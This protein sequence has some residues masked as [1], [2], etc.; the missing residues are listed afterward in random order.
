[1]IPSLLPTLSQGLAY[2][3][4][5]DMEIYG[6]LNTEFYFTMDD[7]ITYVISISLLFNLQRL[8]ELFK[9]E[10]FENLNISNSTALAENRTRKKTKQ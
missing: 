4:S 6:L 10:I 7:R 2:L 8:L 1:M 9:V 3:D 5:I